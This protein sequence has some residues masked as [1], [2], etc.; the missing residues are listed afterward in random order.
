MLKPTQLNGAYVA[1]S[2][3]AAH[4]QASALTP[5]VSVAAAPAL[6]SPPLSRLNSEPP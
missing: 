1:I 6:D 2:P 3:I 4:D 5:P